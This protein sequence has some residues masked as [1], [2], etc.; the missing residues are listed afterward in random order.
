M[1]VLSAFEKIEA[2]I[3]KVG[4]RMRLTLTSLSTLHAIEN[5]A[6]VL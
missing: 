5:L 1:K 6:D 4:R 2:R 3:E